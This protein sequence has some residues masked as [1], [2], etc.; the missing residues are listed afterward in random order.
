M[1]TRLFHV[2]GKAVQRPVTAWYPARTHAPARNG[3]YIVR[4]P[5]RAVIMRYYHNGVWYLDESCDQRSLY[6]NTEQ[7]GVNDYEFCALTAKYVA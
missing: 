4:T 5:V 1:H 3:P 6:M 7:K 2:K